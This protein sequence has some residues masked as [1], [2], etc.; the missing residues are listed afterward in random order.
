MKFYYLILVIFLYVIF[1]TQSLE[2]RA[3]TPNLKF[4]NATLNKIARVENLK[5]ISLSG[6]MTPIY[7]TKDLEGDV[8]LPTQE[9]PEDSPILIQ[10]TYKGVNYNKVIPPK[11]DLQDTKHEIVV[12]ETSDNKNILNIKGLI[13]ITKQNKLLLINKLYLIQNVSNPK[14]TYFSKEGLEV[15]I[16]EGAENVSAQLFQG[17]GMPIPVNLI[18]A[19]NRHIIERGILPGESS[20]QIS[21]TLNFQ[22]SDKVEFQ[23]VLTLE[24][25]NIGI[26]FIKPTDVKVSSE[27][28]IEE[29][30]D[31]EIPSGMRAFKV[32]YG[33]DRTVVLSLEGGSVVQQ[34]VP[35]QRIVQNGKIFNTTEKSILGVIAILSLLFSLSF[36]FVYRN[37]K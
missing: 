8:V 11:I 37:P 31:E 9:I 10:V 34:N 23:D 28:Q 26:V 13:Q 12:Y 19:S 33:T 6:G 25:E 32:N 22:D 1:N 4:R 3:W 35:Q 14:L 16:P 36:I 27:E 21:Y 7:E 30:S 5:I 24:K 15:Y 18:Q 29:M 2:A 20:L 17:N